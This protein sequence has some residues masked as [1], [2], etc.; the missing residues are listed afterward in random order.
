MSRRVTY[1]VAAVAVV[2]T[3]IAAN[4]LTCSGRLIPPPQI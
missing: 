3:V 1:L 2:A 4:A